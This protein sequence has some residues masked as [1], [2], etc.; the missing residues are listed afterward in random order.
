MILLFSCTNV[1][2]VPLSHQ[3]LSQNFT[4][5]EDPT[6]KKLYPLARAA[7]VV[8]RR[9]PKTIE[10]SHGGYLPTKFEH[11]PFIGFACSRG[12]IKSCK[13][14][15]RSQHVQC[16]PRINFLCSVVIPLPRCANV[17]SLVSLAYKFTKS[18]DL[19]CEKFFLYGTCN[20]CPSSPLLQWCVPTL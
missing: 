8:H 5:S 13:F 1:Q 10:P 19:V 2:S 17:P 4:N 11:N 14:C 16:A 3:P 18:E 9:S 20:L 12:K 6:F 15:A 7:C